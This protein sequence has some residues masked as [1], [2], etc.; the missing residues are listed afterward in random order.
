MIDSSHV[1]LKNLSIHYIGNKSYEDQQLILSEQPIEI[2]ELETQSILKDFLTK[3]FIV[4][5]YYAFKDHEGSYGV[6][7]LYH[8][9]KD[10]FERT[11]SFHT[12]SK[13]FARQLY[14]C[15]DHPSIKPGHLMV[16][17]LSE[18][19]FDDEL[20]EAIVLVKIEKLSP[21]ATLNDRLNQIT[22]HFGID[23]NRI[24]KGA[25]IYN[26]L[27][28]EGYRLQI[29]NKSPRPFETQY[30]NDYFLKIHAVTSDFFQTKN[31][32][33]ITKSYVTNQLSAD[34]EVEKADK[35]DMLNKSATFFKDEEK[36]DEHTFANMVFDKPEIV[37][38]FKRYRDNY[39]NAHNLEIEPNFEIS[40][41]AVKK[42]NRIFKSVIKLDKNFHIYIHGDKSRIT[43][44][45]DDSG[46]KYYKLYFDSE[47]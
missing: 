10:T 6:H 31:Y 17:R 30:W 8:L 14:D 15:V 3:Y 27:D 36:F 2:H 16:A 33:N 35:I 12:Q 1:Q 21:F 7:P 44:G 43:K 19:I 29:L 26:A 32:M 38:S 25:I 23:L 47:A 45:T 20:V 39:V 28:E 5:D 41:P 13:E 37:E 22:P 34:F 42:Y 24:D 11:Q 18:F 46:K 9:V 4:P 40:Q